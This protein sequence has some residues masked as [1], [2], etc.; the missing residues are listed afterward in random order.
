MSTDTT[1]AQRTVRCFLTYSGIKLPL[2]LSQELDMAS[3]RH[4]NTYF[5]A[6]YDAQGRM[7]RCDKMVYGEVEM[8][9]DYRYN[10]DGTLR[11]AIVTS[12]DEDEPQVLT[13]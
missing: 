8:R 12:S 1:E 5:R 13:F 3:L 6:E 9:H 11:E 7:R 10:D 2:Q 4:R